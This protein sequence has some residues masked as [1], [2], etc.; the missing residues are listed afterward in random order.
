VVFSVIAVLAIV[1]V[2]TVFAV[3]AKLG[4]R[5]APAPEKERIL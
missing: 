1:V 2:V 5:R 3:R 4:R